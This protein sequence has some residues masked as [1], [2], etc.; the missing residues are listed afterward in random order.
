[1]AGTTIGG[2]VPSKLVFL[3][4]PVRPQISGEQGECGAF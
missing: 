4:I 2:F 1:M 3:L